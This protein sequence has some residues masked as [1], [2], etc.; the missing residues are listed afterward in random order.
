M[1]RTRLMAIGAITVTSLLWGT[2]GTAATFAPDAGPLAI[3]AAALGIGGLLQALIAIPSLRASRGQL[4]CN[5]RLV[6][7]GAAAVAIYPLAFYSSM[8]LAGVALGSVVSLASAPLASG[9]LEW[10]AH[11]SPLSR[12][13]LWAA[14]LGVS[15]STLLCLSKMSHDT[16]DAASTFAGIALG[17]VAGATYATYSWCAQCLM[18]QG[19]NRAA[20]MGSIF[21]VGGAL[22][23]PVLF[24]TGA[25]LMASPQAFA[26]ASYMALIPM[27]LG[28][29]LF[30]YG[31]SKVTASTA[32][33]IT[34]SEP[35]VAA[36]LAV[37]VVG[38]RLSTMGW[39]GLGIIGLALT[40]LAVAPANT[41][42]RVEVGPQRVDSGAV[43]N[44]PSGAKAQGVPRALNTS[45]NSST[46]S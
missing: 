8:H 31:L 39:I 3:G 1:N 44:K 28:Y 12:W 4:R 26:V 43:A 34:L 24:L 14:T 40:V 10:L 20:A 25:P 38:E 19:I 30:G 37:V 2:T 35:A 33:T 27:F 11:R 15:G 45:T 13:W 32:T 29:L 16:G 42:T 36:I 46:N 41:V 22:L 21:G 7:L 9:V 5:W 18:S 17:L 6:G 23:L